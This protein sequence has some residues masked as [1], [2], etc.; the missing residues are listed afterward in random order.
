MFK[1]GHAQRG[2]AY[3]SLQFKMLSILWKGSMGL[4]AVE[5]FG[6]TWN[7]VMRK[8]WSIANMHIWSVLT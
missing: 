7:N 2:C 1:F 4:S 5:H 8:L 6:I 3:D